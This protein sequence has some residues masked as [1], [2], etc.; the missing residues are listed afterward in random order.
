[1]LTHVHAADNAAVL[2]VIDPDV[3]TASTVTSGWVDASKFHGIL[4][5]VLAGDLGT[6]ATVDAK[7][8]QADTSA[9]GNAKDVAGSDITQMT[10]AGTD[11]SNT[12]AV[13]SLQPD[14]LDVDNGFRWVRLSIT[15]GTATSDAGGVVLGLAP[16][17][18]PADDNDSDDV[19]EVVRV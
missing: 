17:V 14:A 7:L 16:R 3:T 2:S 4:A 6:N 9:G 5:I 1:M 8:E 13:I 11:Q 12:Q 18:G 19:G 15:V 10:Q